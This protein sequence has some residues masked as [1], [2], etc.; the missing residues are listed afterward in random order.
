ME[1][2]SKITFDSISKAK[3]HYRKILKKMRIERK[4]MLYVIELSEMIYRDYFTFSRYTVSNLRFDFSEHIQASLY[5]NSNTLRLIK[6]KPYILKNLHK[7]SLHFTSQKC[8]KPP[9]KH[10]F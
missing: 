2:A 4:Q 9:L 10:S 8:S 5:I 6:L 7:S 3:K 1:A